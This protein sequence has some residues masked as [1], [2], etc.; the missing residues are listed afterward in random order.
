M[1][2]HYHKFEKNHVLNFFYDILKYATYLGF[3]KILWKVE[4]SNCLDNKSDCR[5]R[6]LSK[7]YYWKYL[8]FLKIRIGTLSKL[9]FHFPKKSKFLLF[10]YKELHQ[11]TLMV[12]LKVFLIAFTLELFFL[13]FFLSFFLF[14]IWH[15]HVVLS[16]FFSFS[17]IFFFCISFSIT[18]WG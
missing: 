18:E 12:F 1:L 16:A 17:L 13:S 2:G 14:F 11:T 4:S 5:L 9:N 6:F 10:L 7:D 8:S 3:W 15:F